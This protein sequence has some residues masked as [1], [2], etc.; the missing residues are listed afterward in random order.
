MT[1]ARKCSAALWAN[2]LIFKGLGTC[3]HSPEYRCPVRKFHLAWT[4]RETEIIPLPAY[5]GA[6]LTLLRVRRVARL[7]RREI[8]RMGG[9]SKSGD[10]M[11][12]E[13]LFE[14]ALVLMTHSRKWSWLKAWGMK[15]ARHRGMKRAI[16]AV[17]RRL[18][19]RPSPDGPRPAHEFE[20]RT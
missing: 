20:P 12:R 18:A 1:N 5:G 15:I 6:T 14:A 7:R 4:H 3:R 17:A 10:A 11:T 13:M 8:D 2:L 16:V 9:I 19:V